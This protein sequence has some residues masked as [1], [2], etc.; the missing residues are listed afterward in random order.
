MKRLAIAFAVLVAIGGTAPDALAA[1]TDAWLEGYA[2]AVL[3]RQLGITVPSLTVR[4]GV[5]QL[6]AADLG[7]VE[8]DRVVAALSA[9][10]GV[11]RVE[12]L[13]AGAPPAHL[14]PSP[15]GPEQIQILAE[16]STGLLPG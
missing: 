9:I 3:E 10:K 11:V 14:A 16:W 7:P 15:T 6:S 1:Q 13:E 5:I 8:R 12:V 4:H 2:A